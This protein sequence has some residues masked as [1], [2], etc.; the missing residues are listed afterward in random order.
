MA[1]EKV[2]KAYQIYD[3]GTFEQK[4]DVIAKV[5][6]ILALQVF[7]S[8]DDFSP[9]RGQRAAIQQMAQEIELLS[10]S[11]DSAKNR[12]DNSEYPWPDGKG[13]VQTPCL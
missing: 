2:C 7:S 12:P 10:P 1:C 3:K 5:L 8:Q 4:H 6:P 9:R 11:C 13:E